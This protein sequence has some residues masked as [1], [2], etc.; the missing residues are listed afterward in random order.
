MPVHTRRGAGRIC[1]YK[2][3]G[4]RAVKEPGTLGPIRPGGLAPSCPAIC[5]YKQA[6]VRAGISP[7]TRGHLGGQGACHIGADPAR[8]LRPQGCPAICPYTGA[9][10]RAGI[11]PY[12]RVGFWAVRKPGISVLI[13]PGSLA[14][15]NRGIGLYKWTARPRIW[16]SI[17]VGN[18]RGNLPI[19]LAT[20]QYLVQHTWRYLKCGL[21]ILPA[22]LRA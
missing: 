20:P 11:R 19:L 18:P 8:R 17:S 5:G 7:Q 14:P 9:G 3:F 16:I 12:K 13:R 6:G 21:P 15:R 1:L 22:V 10:V 2:R 4:V